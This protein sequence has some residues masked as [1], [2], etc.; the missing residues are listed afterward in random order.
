[1]DNRLNIFTFQGEY[2]LKKQIKNKIKYLIK[3]SLLWD[4]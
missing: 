2:Y 4:Y 1:M 3:S